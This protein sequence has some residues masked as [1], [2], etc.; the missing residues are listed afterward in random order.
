[1][2]YEYG[3]YWFDSPDIGTKKLFMAVSGAHS[4]GWATDYSDLD[5]R[6]VWLPTLLQS[7]SVC[8]RGKPKQTT[9]IFS[10]GDVDFVSYPIRN[11]LGL[12]VKGNGNC[13]ENLY[14]PKLYEDKQLVD[15]LKQLTMENL[16]K[17]FLKHYLGY[18]VGLMKDMSNTT[19]LERYGFCKLALGAYRVLYAGLTLARSRDV[20]YNVREHFKRYTTTYGEHILDM[21][22]DE[23]DPC[24]TLRTNVKD[25]LVCLQ[26]ELNKE[27]S[28]CGWYNIFP[29]IVYDRWLVK[30]Y[31]GYD[32]S[33]Q[34]GS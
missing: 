27:I 14:Q 3:K 9:P 24:Q 31:E 6:E 12:L 4:Y 15:E 26:N 5:V 25:E 20:I 13:L 7:L 28:W 16:H 33:S 32:N 11:F 18:S 21:Y 1:M 29:S 22:Y 10:S 8:F 17:G 23:D 30:Q 34:L 2:K 19:R